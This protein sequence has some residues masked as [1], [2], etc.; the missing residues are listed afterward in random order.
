MRHDEVRTIGA[1][2]TAGETR[3]KRAADHVGLLPL[4]EAGAP[5]LTA[6]ARCWYGFGVLE[7][8][9]AGV[10]DAVAE[11]LT[12]TGRDVLAEAMPDGPL[13]TAR[14]AFGRGLL[15]LQAGGAPGVPAVAN[16]WAAAG[17][18]NR[19]AAA[20]LVAGAV[21]AEEMEK[22]SAAAFA[23]YRLGLATATRGDIAAAFWGALTDPNPRIRDPFE[24]FEKWS[25][26][27]NVALNLRGSALTAEV[28]PAPRGGTIAGR[29]GRRYR[30][31]DMAE[32]AAKINAQAVMPR[33]DF[34]HQSERQ[35]PTFRNSTRAEGWLSNFRM[36]AAGGIDADFELGGLAAA[37]IREG[38][39]RYLSPG[40][41]HDPYGAVVGLSSVALVNN[42]NF[43]L[44]VPAA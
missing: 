10:L 30:V 16:A 40:L 8:G 5:G 3:R 11:A 39:Y 13:A 21:L 6:T 44:T 36:N 1:W 35:S 43:D 22:E 25:A 17:P 32:L 28:I 24:D 9:R 14:N 37:A 19:M 31:P 4:Y 41:L 20:S 34:D 12:P 23:F 15:A 29:D 2:I 42:P 27:L 18:R 38:R 33:V 7:G 26:G